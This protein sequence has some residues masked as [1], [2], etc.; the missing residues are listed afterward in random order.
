VLDYRIEHGLTQSTLGRILGISQPDD[1]RLEIAEPNPSIQT[2][3]RISE[4]LGI[5]IL[6]DIRPRARTEY[7]VSAEVETSA[8]VVKHVRPTD[9]HEMLVAAN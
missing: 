7:W 8:K 2:L 9:G 4:P 5:E 1:A 6:V 3:R